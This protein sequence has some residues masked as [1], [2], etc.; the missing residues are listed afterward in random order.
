MKCTVLLLTVGAA[1]VTAQS[2]NVVE[3]T[4][5]QMRA[6]ME[7]G[8][9]TSRELVSLYLA[10]I[11]LY[12]AKLHAVITTNPAAL[13]EAAERD[14]E[15]AQGGVRGPL[16]GIPIALKDNILTHDIVTTGGALAF[17]GFL[18]PYDATLVKNLRDA[19]A[20]IIAKTGLT[21]LAN[22]V[23]GAPTPMPANYNSVRGFGYNPYDPRRDPRDATND[24]RPALT[25]GGSSSGVGTAA[26]FWAGNVGSE[27]SGSI[28]SPSNQNML[29]AIKPTVGRISRY[30]VIPITADQDTAGP[31]AK[32]V[33]D[34]AILFGAL[35]SPAP[36][37]NDPA[38]STC[39]PAAGRDYTKFLKAD[40]LKGARIGI[41]RAFYYDKIEPPGNAARRGGGG[42][43]GFD[44]LNPEQARVMTEAIDILKQQGAV[45]VDPAD[46]PSIVTKDP[47]KNF[48]LWGQCSGL[49]NV[50]GKDA[51]CSVVLKYGMKR[52][53]N[54][55]LATLG[56]SAPVKTLTE[57]RQWNI[58]HLSAGAIRYG[59]SQ[60]DISDEMD[61]EA[62]RARY[63]SDRA[64]D[65]A[66][67]GT[68]GIDEAMKANHLD[69]LLFP[70]ANGAAI[71]AKPGYPTVIVPFGI[72]P[73]A[74]TPPF[75]PGFDAKPS[76]FGVSFTGMACS[77]PRL[78]ELAYAFEQAT[79][80]RVA[81]A[82]AP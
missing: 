49:T 18:P 60:L 25:T 17:D 44:G 19:G 41:P 54:K 1:T 23:A 70:G 52:N 45:I 36:D 69:A 74:P 43:G 14:R 46:I 77:E 53:F 29:A 20:V 42:R 67:A 57:L 7:Q 59:Q 40:G 50:K 34:A 31:M 71:A 22:W 39:T 61:V 12:D 6:A 10:R 76:P 26:N 3:A 75:P 66:L 48:L 55:W 2:F 30:G 9:I 58:T 11:G 32:T 8:R 65:I 4:I 78:L 35:E 27:T 24:G 79:R 62:D 37:P 5:P 15:R 68:H 16:H 82:S 80:R 51:D 64:K 33:T 73:N 21:E 13:Q 28:L 47:D 38:T 81:P 63:E 72:V 56:P